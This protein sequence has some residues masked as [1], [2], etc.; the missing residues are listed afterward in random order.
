MKVMFEPEG[1]APG[2]PPPAGHYAAVWLQLQIRQPTRLP[3]FAAAIPSVIKHAKAFPGMVRFGFDIDWERA[4]FRTF[5]AFEGRA[6]LRAYID[7][8]PHGTV[9]RKLR[10]RLGDVR[11]SYGTIDE[12]PETWDDLAEEPFVTSQAAHAP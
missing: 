2:A 8:G 11:V 7:D 1:H 5:G 10:G 3:A 12:L 9:Y 4:R 6:A